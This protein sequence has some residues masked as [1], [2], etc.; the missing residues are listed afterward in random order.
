MPKCSC[1]TLN[2][3]RE[4]IIDACAGLYETMAYKDITLKEIGGCT[5]L[6]RT[7]IY[8]YFSTREEIFLA[9]LVRDLCCWTHAIDEIGSEGE[10]LTPATAAEALAKTLAKRVRM[11][12]LLSMNLADIQDNCR[13]ER[14]EEF[15]CAAAA[16]TRSLE[17]LLERTGL[18]AEG[19]ERF[20]SAFSPFVFGLYPFTATNKKHEDCSIKV[21]VPCCCECS[22][23]Y[24]TANAFLRT[25]FEALHATDRSTAHDF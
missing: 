19:R 20:L 17:S 8:N 23:I 12:G 11:L 14:L 15:R 16:M 4:E 6:T 2:R 5:S 21:G 3:K 25:L 1:E 9:L 10:A 24:N 13:A 7:S 18:S 22:N